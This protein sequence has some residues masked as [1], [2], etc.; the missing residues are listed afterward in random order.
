M[1]LQ[2]VIR[3]RVA[4]GLHH[5]L[6]YSDL[7]TPI[8]MSTDVPVHLAVTFLARTLN[9]PDEPSKGGPPLGEY[10]L[11]TKVH[12]HP[13]AHRVPTTGDVPWADATSPTV[14]F[15]D[16]HPVE[17]EVTQWLPGL[18]KFTA[19]LVAEKLLAQTGGAFP[20]DR[21]QLTIALLPETSELQWGLTTWTALRRNAEVVQRVAIP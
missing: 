21:W 18:R 8:A 17:R 3:E 7:E 13:E 6:K 1:I 14:V 4:P 11:L 12:F 9:E 16:V 15:A 10:R 20:G 5:P 19:E 2:H